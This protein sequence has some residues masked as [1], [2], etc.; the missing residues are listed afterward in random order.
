MQLYT[1]KLEYQTT[2]LQIFLFFCFYYHDGKNFTLK[3]IPFAVSVIPPSYKLH[4][5]QF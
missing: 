2:T 4:E 5:E 1:C 3:F